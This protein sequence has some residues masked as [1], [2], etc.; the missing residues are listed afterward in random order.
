MYLD[1]AVKAMQE[2]GAVDERLLAHLSPLPWE[3]IDR[4]GDDVFA[5]Y[6]VETVG[7]AIHKELWVPTEELPA[8]SLLSALEL[9]SIPGSRVHRASR[10]RRVSPGRLGSRWHAGVRTSQLLE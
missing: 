7:S 6:K 5:K 3:H 10:A 9:G 4:T 1:R 2:H 8:A